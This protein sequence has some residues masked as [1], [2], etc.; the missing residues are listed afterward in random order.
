[1]RALENKIIEWAKVRNIHLP[2]NAKNQLLKSFEE[3]GELSSALLKDDQD[4][5]KDAIGDVL[6]TL[7]ILAHAR[8]T[9]LNQCLKIAWKEI[10]DRTG[11]T[12]NGTFVKDESLD[13]KNVRRMFVKYCFDNN[14]RTSYVLTGT[15]PNPFPLSHRNL[16]KVFYLDYSIKDKY[17]IQLLYFINERSNSTESSKKV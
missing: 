3:M 9:N 16:R 5:L 2:E 7:I 1:M 12:I 15:D 6:V 11:K 17:L 4:K 8:G 14:L 13:L 10:K